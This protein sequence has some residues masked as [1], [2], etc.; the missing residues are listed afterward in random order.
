MKLRCQTIFHYQNSFVKNQKL[1]K[2]KTV[3]SFLGLLIFSV[4]VK[5]QLDTKFIASKY[6]EGVVKII[7]VDP[8]LEEVKEGSGYLGRG[9]GFFVTRDGYIFTNSHVIETCVL[10]YVDYDYRDNNGQKRSNLATYSEAII[11]DKSFIKAYNVGYT[12]PLV[13]VFKGDNEED[14]TLY[15]AEVIALGTGSYDGAILKIVSDMEG[16]ASEFN[17]KTLPLGNSNEVV[18]GEQFCVFGYPAQVRGTADL[19]LRD[20]STLSLGIM[21]GKEQVINEDYGYLKTDAEIHPGNS[22]GPVFNER[23]KVIGIATAKGVVTG[24]GLVGGINGMYYVSATDG[25][26][27]QRLVA[28]GLNPPYKSS[29]IN[30]ASGK[31]VPIKSLAEIN[32]TTKGGT[33]E[34][35]GEGP[36]YKNAKIYF[37][38]ISPKDN[39][40]RLPGTSKQFSSFTINRRK[41]GVVWVYIDNNSTPLNTEQIKVVVKKRKITEYK[42]VKD[43]VYNVD[44]TLDVTYFSHIFEKKGAYQFTIY[45]KEGKIIDSSKVVISYE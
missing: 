13:Q 37:S 24:I 18:K 22:G 1:L 5:A 11:S 44:S 26:L 28:K 25:R 10:G 4:V 40:N 14:Y 42:L 19:M 41:G 7:L 2:M 36:F 34:N 32:K 12:V 33:I 20:L 9:S 23:N 6:G 29:S 45:S 3:Y 17:F 21:S 31:R 35:N 27:H 16:K 30:S 43:L 39:K 15:K 38:N 8:K